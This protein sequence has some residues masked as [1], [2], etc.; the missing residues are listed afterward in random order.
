MDRETQM[1][2]PFALQIYR[3]VL[4]GETVQQLSAELGIPKERIER[5]LRAAAAYY[6][7]RLRQAA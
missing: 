5:R 7:R 2:E 3:R 6:R 4:N 1:F